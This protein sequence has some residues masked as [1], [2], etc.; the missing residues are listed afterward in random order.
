M[1]YLKLMEG[2]QL[3]DSDVSHN[4]KLVPIG[5]RD[6]LDFVEV[7]RE[8]YPIND[9]HS[10]KCAGPVPGSVKEVEARITRDACARRDGA[11]DTETY[12]LTGNAY[13]LSESGKTIAHRAC[14]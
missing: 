14:Y 7:L 3:S 12:T 11:A 2:T 1:M 13:V 9:V 8:V 6:T 10:P 4:F 5:P